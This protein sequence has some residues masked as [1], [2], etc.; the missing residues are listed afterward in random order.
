MIVRSG[1]LRMVSMPGEAAR[2]PPPLPLRFG[3][4]AATS[5][6]WQ[7]VSAPASII[8]PAQTAARMVQ[9]S[10]YLLYTP[11]GV[12]PK[13][14]FGLKIPHCGRNKL[15]RCYVEDG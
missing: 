14:S 8:A 10:I 11:D 3:L 6:V 4:T 13:V 7:G 12:A 1:R 5:N 2:L 15:M 9:G